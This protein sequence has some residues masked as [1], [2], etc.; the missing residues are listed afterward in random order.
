[1]RFNYIYSCFLQ[2]EDICVLL[3]IENTDL[4]KLVLQDVR[5][6]CTVFVLLGNKNCVCLL[7]DKEILI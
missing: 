1:M 6:Q 7:Q 4:E 5:I 2:F 3:K